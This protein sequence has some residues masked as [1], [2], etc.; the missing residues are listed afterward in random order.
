[1][2]PVAALAARFQPPILGHGTLLAQ[3]LALAPRVAVGLLGAGEARSAR[4][5]FSEEERVEMIR[6]SVP[7]G[8]A[9]RITFVPLD[10][11]DSASRQRALLAESLGSDTEICFLEGPVHGEAEARQ[12]LYEGDPALRDRVAPGVLDLL[13]AWRATPHFAILQEEYRA[14]LA[15]RER[16]GSGPFVTLDAMVTCLGHLLLV[17]RGRCPGKGLWALPGGFLEPQEFLLD[18]ALREL[19]EETGLDLGPLAWDLRGVRVF[20]HPERSQRGR[21]ITHVHHFTLESPVLPGVKGADDAAEARW[22]PLGGLPAMAGQFFEDHFHIITGL[23]S[24]AAS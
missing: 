10:A 3:A 1:M 23:L 15:G 21:V 9:G 7:A 11:Y 8:E 19:R 13:E 4:H 22:V 12:A 24:G 5:P 16:W 17:R 6:R 2:I 18:G 20:D 14:L